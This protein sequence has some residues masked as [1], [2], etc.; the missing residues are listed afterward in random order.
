MPSS[1]LRQAGVAG[2]QAGEAGE[3]ASPG[4]VGLE[5]DRNAESDKRQVGVQ[6]AGDRSIEVPLVAGEDGVRVAEPSVRD[7]VA[8]VVGL[9]AVLAHLRAS[10]G[11]LASAGR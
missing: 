10:A 5:L 1:Q 9:V 2:L 8:L 4:L 3:A 6:A 7:V 11:G